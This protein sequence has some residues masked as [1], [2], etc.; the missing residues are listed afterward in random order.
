MFYTLLI[1]TF[2]IA[3][4]VSW[5]TCRMFQNPADRILRRVIQDEIYVS[6][7][8]YLK[9]A[10]YVVGVSSGVRIF[11]IE[12]YISAPSYPEGAK[13]L[14]LT[15]ERWVLEIYRT[16]IESLQGLAVVLL[17]FFLA[18]L[19]AFVIVRIVEAARGARPPGT[20]A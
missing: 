5:V 9:F 6:W 2:A 13:I 14:Q 16:V 10:L 7:L 15:G 17:V 4:A 12:R 1:A 20:A 3:L 11:Q 8:T 19:A 18:A